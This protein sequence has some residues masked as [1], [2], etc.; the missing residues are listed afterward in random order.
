MSLLAAPESCIGDRH[1]VNFIA[2]KLLD[3]WFSTF[4]S[5][6]LALTQVVACSCLQELYT[7]TYIDPKQR[8]P[9]QDVLYGRLQENLLNSSWSTSVYSGFQYC[10]ATRRWAFVWVFKAHNL[11]N[12]ACDS[13]CALRCLLHWPFRGRL[14]IWDIPS[15]YQESILSIFDGISP[16]L[17]MCLSYTTHV[18]QEYN[19]P[20]SIQVL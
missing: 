15:G 16:E 13:D 18:S 8:F 12:E 19:R 5:E 17:S 20:V 11:R 10:R 4:L 9:T 6:R 1:S 3:K 14:S 7:S 2:Y